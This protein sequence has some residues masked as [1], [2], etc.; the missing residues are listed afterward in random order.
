MWCKGKRAGVKPEWGVF[1]GSDTSSRKM[2]L[3]GPLSFVSSSR[4]ISCPA[5]MTHGEK[6]PRY[7][8]LAHEEEKKTNLACNDEHPPPPP[9][10]QLHTHT[11]RILSVHSDIIIRRQQVN[12]SWPFCLCWPFQIEPQWKSFWKGHMWTLFLPESGV[13]HNGRIWSTDANAAPIIRLNGCLKKE[14]EEEEEKKENQ[15]C[16]QQ[17]KQ[18]CGQAGTNAAHAMKPNKMEQSRIIKISLQCH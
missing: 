11:H 1:L 16:G 17:I 7:L 10:S 14:E 8:L 6:G 3:S 2:W 13:N 9:P 12:P 4:L 15:R 5:K 18:L